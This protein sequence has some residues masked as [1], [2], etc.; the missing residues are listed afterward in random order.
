MNYRQQRKYLALVLLVILSTACARLHTQSYT[1]PTVRAM[2]ATAVA[3]TT[4]NT[5]LQILLVLR[6]NNA[7]SPSDAKMLAPYLKQVNDFCDAALPVLED[8]KT[9][10]KAKALAR[11][12]CR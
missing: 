5:T 4:V 11:R 7:I 10:D 12:T 1:V 6:N 8:Q 9:S 3:S 2:Q